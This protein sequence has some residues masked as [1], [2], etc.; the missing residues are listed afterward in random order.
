MENGLFKDNFADLKGINKMQL[1]DVG[2]NNVDI[3]PYCTV[4]DNNKFFSYRKE[5]KTQK[6]HSALIKINI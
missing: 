1:N 3:C 5:N 2:V 6:R 4:L